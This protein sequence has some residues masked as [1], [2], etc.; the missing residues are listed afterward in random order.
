MAEGKK[1]LRER[2]QRTVALAREAGPYA[3]HLAEDEKR[4]MDD[5]WDGP[6]GDFSQTDIDCVDLRKSASR[7]SG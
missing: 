2:M 6:S 3:N 1:K 4:F 5:L 7:S